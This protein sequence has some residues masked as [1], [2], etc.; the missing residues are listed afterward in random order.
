MKNA[1]FDLEFIKRSLDIYEFD[2]ESVPVKQVNYVPMSEYKVSTEENLLLY[3]NNLQVCIALY[4]CSNDFG[5]LAHI[6]PLV[7]HGDF[8]VND[9]NNAHKCKRVEEL[10]NEIIKV[11]D[12]LK[13]PI[14]LG[15][16]TGCTP[17]KKEHP[18][19]TIINNDI[20]SMIKRLYES[21]ILVY[22]FKDVVAPEFILDIKK[23]EMI[24]PCKSYVKLK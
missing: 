14:M 4:A 19:I 16:V 20:D 13:E 17:L 22:R 11:K 12:K 9:L 23:K 21:N 2:T 18:N 7:M 6:N 15:I 24:L 3:T 1:D 5:F 10:Y 8:Y